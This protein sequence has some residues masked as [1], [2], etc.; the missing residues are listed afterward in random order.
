[1]QVRNLLVGAVA[2][3]LTTL[4]A[5]EPVKADVAGSTP[6]A[7][8]P[9]EVVLASAEQVSAPLPAVQD[10]SAAAQTPAATPVKKRAARVTTCRCGDQTTQR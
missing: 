1:M 4:A 7:N 3:S 5:A 10:Q 6:P 8:R 9:A 2:M